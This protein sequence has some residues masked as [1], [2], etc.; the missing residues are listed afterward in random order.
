MLKEFFEATAQTEFVNKCVQLPG[1]RIAKWALVEW[2]KSWPGTHWTT[3]FSR[4]K[5]KKSQSKTKVDAM[6]VVRLLRKQ[7]PDK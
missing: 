7:Q 4:E 3:L 5:S 2:E 1:Q 6:G